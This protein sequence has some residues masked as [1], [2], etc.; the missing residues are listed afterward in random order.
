MNKKNF[1][2]ELKKIKQDA[3]E[4]SDLFKQEFSRPNA[5]FSKIKKYTEIEKIKNSIDD[6]ISMVENNELGKYD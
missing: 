3:I 1:I 6:L 5:D 2:E 4:K